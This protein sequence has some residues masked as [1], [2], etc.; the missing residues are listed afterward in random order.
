MTTLLEKAIERVS[1]LPAKKQNM[2]AR[3]LL[4]EIDA[5]AQWDESFKSSQHELAE[6]AGAALVEHHRGRTRKMDLSRDF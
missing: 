6:L 4:A 5:E 2:L 3:L 1:V